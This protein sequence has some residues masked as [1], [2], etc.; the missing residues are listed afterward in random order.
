MRLLL[1]EQYRRTTIVRF[2]ENLHDK[3]V[4]DSVRVKAAIP[5]VSLLVIITCCI[6]LLF[7]IVDLRLNWL[8]FLFSAMALLTSLPILRHPSI[9]RRI[10]IITI[11]QWSF[12]ILFQILDSLIDINNHKMCFYLGLT[13]ITLVGLYLCK[14]A[15]NN[16]KKVISENMI[17]FYLYLIPICSLFSSLCILFIRYY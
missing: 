11:T 10:K 6:S 13:E 1:T 2:M 12:Y 16:K 4:I 9:T 3:V 8:C 5:L 15:F 7:Y 14:I 17:H